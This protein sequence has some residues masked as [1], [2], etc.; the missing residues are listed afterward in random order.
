MHLLTIV[1]GAEWREIEI[2]VGQH[3]TQTGHIANG[4][5]VTAH[6]DDFRSRVTTGTALNFGA[7]RVGKV[8]AIDGFLLEDGSFGVSFSSSSES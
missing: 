5:S 1:L 4:R 8:D 2:S 6:P 3:L 7:G